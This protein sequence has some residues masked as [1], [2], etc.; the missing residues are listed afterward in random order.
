MASAL[1]GFGESRCTTICCS[2]FHQWQHHPPR[3]LRQV[4]PYP[5][6]H[7]E[8]VQLDRIVGRGLRQI[9]LHGTD[10]VNSEFAVRVIAYNLI[11]LR[12]ILRPSIAAA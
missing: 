1:S 10:K 7:R 12:N 9:K 2:D 5:P 4:E 8:S 6:R 3:G 11:R